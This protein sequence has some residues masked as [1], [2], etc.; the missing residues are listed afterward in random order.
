[1]WVDLVN[2]CGNIF[3]I[4]VITTCFSKL[5]KKR[6]SRLPFVLLC[7]LF[8]IMQFLSNHFLLGKS[9]LVMIGMLTFIFLTS[10]LYKIKMITRVLWTVLLH[11]IFA[12]SEMVVAMTLLSLLD[13]K[14]EETYSN[15][16]LFA[17]CTLMSKFIT[18]MIIK[19][20]KIDKKLNNQISISFSWKLLPLPVST[21]A[22]LILLFDYCFNITDTKIRILIFIASVLLALST[23]YIFYI[24]EKQ[25]DLVRT[26][27][28]L[29]FAHAQIENQKKHYSELYKHQNQ[30]RTFRHDTK[31]RLIA[32]SAL[33]KNGENQKA[34]D[35]LENDI[36]FIDYNKNKV[37]NS[38][39]PIIDAVIQS[40]SDIAEKKS[41][42]F[43]IAIKLTESIKIDEFELGVLIGNALDNAIEAT[44]KVEIN[45]RLPIKIS[46]MTMKNHLIFTVT[47]L[48]VNNID[49]NKISTTKLDKEN[50]GYGINSM[51]EIAVKYDGELFTSCQNNIFELN[52][53]IVNE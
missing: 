38:G 18:F 52:I 11:L 9:G 49:V 10:L 21:S 2:I 31:N 29:N 53:N 24:I 50:H 27:E 32:L 22:V 17:L 48:V 23:I 40:K 14:V 20:L 44:E 13:I 51:R 5:A 47:N 1:M 34:L 26:K 39:N 28:S 16:F 19:L 35:M 43:D 42:E 36:N 45:K 25:N 8:T 4:V 6:V 41:V 15:T 30:L 46:L 3:E 37:I 7:I 12:M 33:I